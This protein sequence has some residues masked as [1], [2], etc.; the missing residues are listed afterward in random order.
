MCPHN[1]NTELCLEISYIILS[2]KLS[3]TYVMTTLGSHNE[4][5]S[6]LITL[7]VRF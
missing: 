1:A 4:M 5:I 2:F 6:V 3:L 7:L